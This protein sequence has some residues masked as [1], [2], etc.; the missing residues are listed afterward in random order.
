[1]GRLGQCLCSCQG[2]GGRGCSLCAQAARGSRRWGAA[3]RP[4]TPDNSARGG[5]LRGPGNFNL[6]CWPQLPA[7]RTA[8]LGAPI[9]RARPGRPAGPPRQ[10][11]TQRRGRGAVAP[12]ASAAGG[13]CARVPG[14]A[15]GPGTSRRRRVCHGG[16]AHPRSIA[17]ALGL[18][19]PGPLL[20]P[21]PRLHLLRPVDLRLLLLD[22]RPRATS[23][24]EMC[25]E[26][27]TGPVSAVCC[28]L[29]PDQPV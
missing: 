8:E 29:P 9:S 15:G 16:G 27:W 1:M 13:S 11:R 12:T 28:V 17:R 26:I 21:P 7:P 19:L 14:H 18:G 10:S 3:S 22:R 5:Q 2:G 20:R 6:E 24:S 4:R 23:L 25:K